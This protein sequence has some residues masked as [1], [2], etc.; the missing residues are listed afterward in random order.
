MG[1][2]Y[3][4]G[5]EKGEGPMSIGVYMKSDY[6]GW[7]ELQYADGRRHIDDVRKDAEYRI[8]IFYGS[9]DH[10]IIISSEEGSEHFWNGYRQM[11]DHYFKQMKQPLPK[12][13]RERKM[14]RKKHYKAGEK[15]VIDNWFIE[16]ELHFYADCEVERTPMNPPLFEYTFKFS[17]DINI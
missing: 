3:L 10:E 13:N 17:S 11:I 1:K 5:R 2:R 12:Y 8:E 16:I 4:F 7:D 15:A 9:E 6:L 14:L